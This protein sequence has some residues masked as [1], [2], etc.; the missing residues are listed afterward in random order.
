M[1]SKSNNPPKIGEF[2]NLPKSETE[3]SK[4]QTIAVFASSAF[5]WMIK[6]V[7]KLGTYKGDVILLLGWILLWKKQYMIIPM[8]D[9]NASIET[10][11][12]FPNY[13]FAIAGAVIAWTIAKIMMMLIAPNV[14]EILET[15]WEEV[16]SKLTPWEK[17][18]VSVFLFAMVY[19]SIIFLSG[20]GG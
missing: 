18:R 17:I 11:D 14:A 2:I 3:N 10:G 7:N 8:I 16:F 12:F 5:K 1:G 15:K 6:Q 19:I 13:I 20:T 9:P 4:Q